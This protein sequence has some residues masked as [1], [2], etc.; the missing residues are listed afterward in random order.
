MVDPAD[1]FVSSDRSAKL[2]TVAIATA[3]VGVVG[4]GAWWLLR[5]KGADENPA[6]VLIVG[7]TPELKGFLEDAGFDV[8][9]LSLGEA[10]GQGRSFDGSLEDLP[11]MLEYADQTGFGYLA[12]NMAHGERY[13]FSALDVEVAEPPEGTAFAVVSVGD[14]GT[15]V[16][17]GGVVPEV[18]HE[19]PS[20]EQVGLLLA[21]FDQP[22]IAKARTGDGSND[23]LI[24]FGA[25]D[26]IKDVIAYEKA[27]ATMRRQAAAWHAL[28]ERERGETKPIELANAYEPV[29]GWP[30]ANGSLLLAAG[31]DA[32][33]SANGLSS[34]WVGEDLSVALS[35]VSLGDPRTRIPC[36]SL[37]DALSVDGFSV[38][39]A[40]DALLIPTDAWV[41]DL[42]VLSGPDCGFEQRDPIRRLDGGALGTPRAS[43]RTAASAGGRLMWADAKMQRYR[44]IE[45]DG[46]ALRPDAL[47][48]LGDDLVVVPANLDF[49]VA[50]QARADR[51]ALAVDPTGATM[52]APIN[53]ATQPLPSEALVFVELPAPDVGDRLR[54]AVVPI[55]ALLPSEA[56]RLGATIR[57]VFPLEAPGA[58]A[59]LVD[60]P[61]G[62]Q[63]VRATIGP[64]DSWPNAIAVEFDLAA[65]AGSSSAAITLEPLAKLPAQIDDLA[66]SPDARRVAWAAPSESAEIMLL[67]LGAQA[68]PVRLTNN[69]RPDA[70][71]RFV[72]AHL[73]FDSIYTADDELPSVEAV[74]ALEV[75]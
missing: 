68:E 5:G 8:N 26:T 30:L 49:A 24:R 55:A 19:P 39:P 64:R 59:V 40:G 4:A 61:A 47:H 11:A 62:P 48:W 60:G 74:R 34:K 32:W 6:R 46:V 25:K 38:A 29:R 27:Q 44:S 36:T 75:P 52:T 22:E 18:M 9:Q 73:I 35:V 63:L 53:P 23:L 2:R 41:A 43:G 69:D 42:W 45:L 71:P 10:I 3:L 65:A 14:L 51:M 1:S 57:A 66:I 31:R 20:A 56:D 21:L 12:L 67:A 16:T 70:H 15:H 33:R 7:P 58:V 50:A 37:P 54:V 17:F 13:D 28:A 72:G